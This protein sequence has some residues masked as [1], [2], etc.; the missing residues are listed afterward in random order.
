VEREHTF[1]TGRRLSGFMF[2]RDALVA[3]L[4]DKTA[5]SRNGA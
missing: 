1:A 4:Y 3:R 2:G 5:R